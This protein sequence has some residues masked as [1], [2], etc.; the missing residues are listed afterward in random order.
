MAKDPATVQKKM[1]WV[2]F[3]DR[4]AVLKRVITPAGT[5]GLLLRTATELAGE[6]VREKALAMGFTELKSRGTLRILFPDGKVT[7]GARELAEKLGG[8]LIGLTREELLSA[9]WTIN[10]SDRVPALAGAGQAPAPTAAAAP[11]V[12]QA[13]APIVP[14]MDS[15]VSI[16][17]NTRGEEV[18]FDGTHRFYRAVIADTGAS[19]FVVEGPGERPTLFLRATRRED[20]SAIASSLVAQSLRG[21]LH[22]AQFD[23]VVDAALEAGPHGQLDMPRAEA[24]EIVR[25]EMIREITAIAIDNDASR[26][27]FIHALRAAESARYVLVRET[28]PGTP[29]SPSPALSALLRRITRGNSTVDFRG[30][31][32]LKISMPPIQSDAAG[33]ML[34]VH[35]LAGVSEDGAPAYAAN[36]LSR[37]AATGRTLFLVPEAFSED[38]IERLRSDIGRIY[39]LEGVAR[40]GSAV[41]DGVQGGED[42]TVFFIGERRPE[43][44]EALPQAAL[45]DFPV[46]TAEDLINLEREV[47]RSRARLKDFNDGV[48][49]ET[50]AADDSREENIRQKPYQPLS[51]IS[52]PFTMIPVALE[53]ATSKSLE[54]VHRDAA[55]RGG[56]DAVVAGM[57]GQGLDDLAQT[58]TAEQ[59]DAL[60]LWENA[61]SRGRGFLLADQTGVGK[62]R[63]LAAMARAFL[64]GGENRKVLYFTESAAINAPD[65]YRDIKDVGALAEAR[66]IFLTSGTKL[67]DKVVDPVTGLE[68]E[69]ELSNLPKARRNAIFA[70]E[71]WPA[72]CNLVITTYSQFRS[73][74]DDPS[75]IWL[76]NALDENTLVIFDEAHNALNPRSM[77]GINA[78]VAIEGVGRK[79]NVVFGTATPTRDPSGL[80]LYTPLLPDMEEA[81]AKELLENMSAGGEVAQE[82]FATMQAADGVMLRRDHDLSNIEFKVDLP[83]DETMLRYQEVMNLFSPAA[84][85]MID[86]N[87]QIGAHLGR[88]QARE[89]HAMRARGLSEEAARARTNAANQYSINLGSP[90]ASISRV[91]MNAIKTSSIIQGRAGQIVETVLGEIAEGRKPLITF[92]STNAGL[93]QEVSRGPD[94]QTSE[95]AMAEAAGLTL[96]DQI[97]RI[98]DSMYKIKVDDEI[99]DAREVYPDIAEASRLITD[100][101]NRLPADLSCSPVDTLIE[102]L[103]SHGIS[104]GEISGRTLCYRDGRV[105]R[106]SVEERNRRATINKFNDGDLDVMIYNGAGATGGSFHASSKFKD[107]RPRTMIELEAPVDVIKYVQALGRGN[108]YGQV[109]RPRVI[110]VM[111]GLTPEMRILQQRNRKL[112]SLGASVDGNRAHPLLLDDIPDLLNTVGDEAAHNVLASMPALARRMG[113]TDIA[114]AALSANR[115][116]RAVDNGSGADRINVIDSLANKVLARS[117]MLSA[118]D[119]DNL[120]QRIRI[121]FDALIEELESRNANPL[122]PKELDGEVE[123]RA[124][125]L[126]SGVETDE[127]DIDTS[128][129]ISPLYIHTA[130]HHFTEEAWTGDKLV[131]AIEATRRLY[132][133]EGFEPWAERIMQNLPALM[134]P[135]LPEGRDLAEAME[136]PAGVNAGFRQ[137]HDRYTNLAWL[138]ENMKPGVLV[139]FPDDKDPEAHTARIITGLVP[140]AH[141]SLYDVPSAYKIKTISPGMSKPETTAVSRIIWRKMEAIKFRPGLSE[142]F[143]ETVLKK[144][145]DDALMTLRLPVQILSG[146][147]LQA[148][149]EAARNKLGSISLYRDTD[150]HVHR[151]IV[152]EKSKIDLSKIPVELNSARILAEMA[153]RFLH[154]DGQ[155]MAGSLMFKVWGSHD[156]DRKVGDIEDAD[157]ALYMTDNTFTVDSVPLRKSTAGFYRQRPGLYE[158][159]FDKPLPPRDQIPDRAYRRG[160]NNAH[161]VRMKMDEAGTAERMAVIVHALDG[162]PMLTDGRNRSLLNAVRIDLLRLGVVAP[163]QEI[164]H[165][166]PAEE[167]VGE[168]PEGVEADHDAGPVAVADDAAAAAEAQPQEHEPVEDID[169]DAMNWN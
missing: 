22:Q 14:N 38:T 157:F 104:V 62:G 143:S 69:V 43:P 27:K 7:F 92:H 100:A 5:P 53:G 119:Q 74:D 52:E 8:T 89:Y 90:M 164:E 59:V 154:G 110:S 144:F 93:L 151:G 37:R 84:E 94:G 45:R 31:D 169:F 51:K 125:S 121:E 15:I 102:Q 97:Q 133:A 103:E 10:L 130:I 76:R 99:Q 35:D 101:I 11:V 107:S 78:R 159:I 57:L 95:E 132:G 153:H 161:R 13:P 120:V 108:R 158:A 32:D 128:A 140:P 123:I 23:K 65:V 139:H 124:T 24:A 91:A 19:R 112:R 46:V 88:I 146:N 155:Q 58:L 134:R 30:S 87:L 86:V 127:T 16:G 126:F 66:T 166:G 114:D 98:H 39:G 1:G 60:A 83:D 150:G 118:A 81:A 71:A 48:E 105:Q 40:I 138:L 9:T 17:T 61:R 142:S 67:T 149:N 75:S 29:L 77:Q 160:E 26:E 136:N 68:M 44:L 82:A 4:S 85:L 167:I 36:V 111:T 54:R 56:V 21:T 156:V 49:A 148:I 72:D 70:S 141:P 41:A 145:D 63:S 28:E 113:F 2:K 50:A 137:H 64:R 18:I 168:N 79:E 147:I 80:N 122:R 42:S 6:T 115:D 20:L 47:A 73:K 116:N 117:L 96:R 33:A 152:V 109:H 25:R 12:P 106:R 163:D 135:Y 131:T 55:E 3:D 129:F 165:E 162:L 34:Q